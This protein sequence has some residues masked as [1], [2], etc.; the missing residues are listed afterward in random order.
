MHYTMGAARYVQGKSLRL[1][2]TR[3]S[4]LAPSK[5]E[6]MLLNFVF[7]FTLLLSLITDLGDEIITLEIT[8]QDYP[9]QICYLG[10]WKQSPHKA[11]CWRLGG[12]KFNQHCYVTLL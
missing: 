1:D 2:I 11:V 3:F 4:H 5:E 9:I 10:S 12:A 6:K 8:A 7:Y